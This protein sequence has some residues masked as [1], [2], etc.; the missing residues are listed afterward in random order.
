MAI[1]KTSLQGQVCSRGELVLPTSLPSRHC[2]SFP[3]AHKDNEAQGGQVTCFMS[4]ILP[5]SSSPLCVARALPSRALLPLGSIPSP[6]WEKHRRKRRHSRRPGCHPPARAGTLDSL[7]TRSL[8]QKPPSE[9]RAY[10]EVRAMH[11]APPRPPPGLS[12]ESNE[13]IVSCACRGAWHIEKRP[14]DVGSYHD[15]IH[16]LKLEHPW[17]EKEKEAAKAPGRGRGHPRNG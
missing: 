1:P 2:C 11:S 9:S 14:E 7:L 12:W 17:R 15:W 6:D 13:V 8:L 4:Q 10:L 16:P 3:F 5:V